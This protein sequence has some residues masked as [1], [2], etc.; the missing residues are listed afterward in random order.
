MTRLNSKRRAIFS[1]LALPI[2]LLTSSL[3]LTRPGEAS[4]RCHPAYDDVCVPVQLSRG[5]TWNIRVE[6]G[7]K[8]RPLCIKLGSWDGE[9]PIVIEWGD[10][11]A[12]R[13]IKANG[14]SNAVM[15]RVKQAK[16]PGTLRVYSPSSRSIDYEW[17]TCNTGMA[18][19]IENLRWNR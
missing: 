15:V 13:K 4:D 19:N 11:Y 9:N 10:R 18:S 2:A 1:S 5:K 7:F 3:A 17:S 6:S 12:A 14:H 16:Q 8:T